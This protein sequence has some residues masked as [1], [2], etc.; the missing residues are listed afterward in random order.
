VILATTATIIASQAV[1]TGAF[2]LTWQAI[3]LGFLPRF[4]IRHTSDEEIG[5][6]FIPVVNTAL[7]VATIA[8]VVG[9]RTSSALASAYGVAVTAT[10]VIT[11]ALLFVVMRRLWR[12]GL[13]PAL[14]VA[15]AFL[16][17]DLAFFGANIIKI[18]DGGWFPLVVGV[19]IMTVMTTWRTGRRLLE[20]RMKERRTSFEELKKTRERVTRVPGTG[21]F[22][23]R[24]PMDVPPTIVRI[25]RHLNAI[26][27]RVVILSIQTERVPRVPPEMRLRVDALED[28]MYRVVARYGFNEMPHVPR[29]LRR[30]AEQGL[31]VDPSEVSYVMSRET[32]VATRRRG[33][34]MWRE[35]LFSFM[36]RNSSLASDTFR[37][38]AARVLEIGAEI[39]L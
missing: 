32:L 10:M 7:L 35:R 19:G 29:L 27:D 5:H 12:W 38:P 8:L 18:A 39:E 30:C 6:V 3:Q 23:E 4:T 25:Q 13:V 15:A 26:F 34:A 22:L 14:L 11:T 36:A 16:V 31:V 37:I 20:E 21:V 24:D 28:N 2:S 9:F 17:V 1:I 33:M